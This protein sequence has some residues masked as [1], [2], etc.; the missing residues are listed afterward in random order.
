MKKNVLK[1]SLKLQ[2]SR[3]TLRF[4]EEPRLEA[5]HGGSLNGHTTNGLRACFEP[6]SYC[7]C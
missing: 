6:A 4:L 3:E 7:A 5:A 2:V 1:K